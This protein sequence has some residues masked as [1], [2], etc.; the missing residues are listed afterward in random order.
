M[1]SYVQVGSEIDYT[2]SS[3]VASGAVV[4]QGSL[5]GVAKRTIPADTVGALS[6]SG[7]FAF[8]KDTSTA[9]AIGTLMYWDVAD[10][11]AT[12]DADGG[13]NKLIGKVVKAAATADATVDILMDQ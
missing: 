2:P 3:E 4:V 5:V 11:E 12:E 6:V 1:A 7:V 9:H 8:A 13:T 10:Q